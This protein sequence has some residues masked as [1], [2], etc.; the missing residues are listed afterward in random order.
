MFLFLYSLNQTKFMD[1][2]YF[3]GIDGGA[4][5]ST[6]VLINLKGKKIFE[7]TGESLNYRNLDEEKF[8]KN[9]NE[10]II[11][12]KKKG[13]ILFSCF[14]FAGIDTE[15]D[16]KRVMNII[17]KSAV[18]KMLNS[19]F[20]VTNDIEIVL[21]AA[22][23][24]DGAAVIAGTGSNFFA[25]N[26]NKMARAGGLDYILSDEGS[27]FYIG[28]KVLRAAVKSS[29][30]RG[31]KT[32]LEKLV[33]KKSGVENMRDLVNL[34][35]EGNLKQKVGEFAPL[36]EP[37]LK[38]NDRVAKRILLSAV[39]ELENGIITVTRKAKLKG[40]FKIC[41]VGGVFKNKY[42]LNKLETKLKK[43]FKKAR[44]MLIKNPAIGAAKLAKKEFEKLCK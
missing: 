28:Q 11:K 1:K 38:K 36:T 40:K 15:T 35:Y 34:V 20:I 21:L 42:L 23:V 9:L 24:E 19:N 14:S 13:K 10:L 3:L 39:D 43:R 22:N 5:K 29:D 6:L 30:L 27:A 37:A 16:K 25:K 44:I 2:G 41:L 4:T 8:I 32:I 18:N 31:E 33:L 12:A 7:T 26:K 17:E